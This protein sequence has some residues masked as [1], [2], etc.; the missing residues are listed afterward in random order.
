MVKYEILYLIYTYKNNMRK[1]TQDEFIN[2]CKNKHSDRYDYS[3][4]KYKGMN[5]KVNIICKIHGVF[6]QKARDHING[7]N[8]RYCVNNNIK[9]TNSIFIDKC[10]NTHG[11]K[12]DYSLSVYLNQ[13]TKVKI[14]CKKHGCFEQRPN[15]HLRNQG[16]PYCN[17]SKGENNICNILESKNIKYIRQYKFN[18]CMNILPLPFD[19]YLPDYKT[20]IEFDGIQHFKPIDFWGGKQNLNYIKNNDNIKNE[21]CKNNNIKLIRIKYNHKNIEKLLLNNIFYKI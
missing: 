12:Y 13:S 1:I 5:N 16:C 3:L 7:C 2:K 18:D 9:S 17:E 21:Y 8:C 15:S 19:F 20:C 14:I 11:D 6:E 10:K 4:T